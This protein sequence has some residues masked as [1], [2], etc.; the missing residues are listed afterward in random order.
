MGPT[1]NYQYNLF[2]SRLAINLDSICNL[3]SSVT[4]NL[5]YSQIVGIR[6]WASLRNHYMSTA[7]TTWNLF[8]KNQ[9]NFLLLPKFSEKFITVNQCST[10]SENSKKYKSQEL[11]GLWIYSICKLVFHLPPFHTCWHKARDLWARDKC[12][13]I[14]YSNNIQNMVIFAPAMQKEPDD[15][16]MCCGLCYRRETMN[17]GNLDLLE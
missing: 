4:Y 7:V 5:T 3:D 16:R 17:L 11:K 1:H 12:H 15:I 14:T 6:M 2:I 9:V 13:F 10:K 8:S